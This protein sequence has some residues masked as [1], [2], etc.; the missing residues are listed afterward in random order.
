MKN[1][2]PWMALRSPLGRPLTYEFY[3]Y[4][5]AATT[6]LVSSA[7][8]V[9]AGDGLTVWQVGVP[10][11]EDTIYYWRA[12]AADGAA[13]G[14]WSTER[15]A[16]TVDVVPTVGPAGPAGPAG[17]AGTP[18]KDGAGGCSSSAGSS[19]PWQVFVLAAGA[20]LRPR[21]RRG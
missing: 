13:K 15:W 6:Q 11:S 20:V 10:L 9:P 12:R 21:R 17:Q 14:A 1:S 5:D 8:A 7:I 3:V 2:L 19:T 4:S 18:G 16:F